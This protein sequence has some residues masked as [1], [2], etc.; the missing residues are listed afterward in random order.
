M[1]CLRGAEHGQPRRARPHRLGQLHPLL[2]HRPGH[3]ARHLGLPPM[4][5]V[6]DTPARPARMDTKCR[7]LT[8]AP[9]P[10][11]TDRH[12]PRPGARQQHDTT[13]QTHALGAGIHS[14]RW[15]DGCTTTTRLIGRTTSAL[16]MARRVRT[17]ASGAT[18]L[19]A[20]RQDVPGRTSAPC[21][22]DSASHRRR[23]VIKRHIEAFDLDSRRCHDR[24]ESAP[25][26][27]AGQ[28]GG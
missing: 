28:S 27:R 22:G 2:R 18:R 16:R 26:K 19:R 11:S 1:Q 25:C 23:T 15:V 10:T 17:A 7:G 5:S 24:P 14:G 9:A 4:Y 13:S 3:H 12:T 21:D 20:P 6:V 8:T